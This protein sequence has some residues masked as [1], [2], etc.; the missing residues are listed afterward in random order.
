[1]PGMKTV[2]AVLC[3]EIRIRNQYLVIW[4]CRPEASEMTTVGSRRSQIIGQLRVAQCV[5]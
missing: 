3:W 5:N 4:L 1:M 2:E